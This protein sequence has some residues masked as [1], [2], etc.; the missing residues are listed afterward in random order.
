[1]K[2]FERWPL[3][4]LASALVFVVGIGGATY[5]GALITS[6]DIKNGTIKSADVRDKTLKLDDFSDSAKDGLKGATGDKGAA[7]DKGATGDKGDKGDPGDKGDKG[8]KGDP[9]DKGDQ[10]DPGP[11]GPSD[12]YATTQTG[13]TVLTGSLSTVLSL[14]LPAGK[15]VAHVTA[16]AFEATNAA[17]FADCVLSGGGG[18]GESAT[19]IPAGGTYATLAA[20]AVISSASDFALNFRCQGTNTGINKIVL[21]ATKVGALHMS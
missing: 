4:V 14:N 9:G 13:D 2:S 1:M 17:A 10:G 20:Q 21:T 16:T 3:I 7:G 12:A 6:S 5:A 19:T 11:T 8:D 15:Y 18:F